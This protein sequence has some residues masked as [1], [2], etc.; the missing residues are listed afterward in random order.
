VI[1]GGRR[2]RAVRRVLVVHFVMVVLAMAGGGCV[3]GHGVRVD[4]ARQ[5]KPTYDEKRDAS[6]EAATIFR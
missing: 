5:S 6:P 2:G 4:I 1:I 3:M